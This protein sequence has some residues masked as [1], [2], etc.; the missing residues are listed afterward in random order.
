MKKYS[1]KGTITAFYYLSM[2][3]GDNT[4]NNLDSFTEICR[5]IDSEH[6]EEYRDDLINECESQKQ[7]MIDDDDYYDVIIEG[8]DKT[9]SQSLTEDDKSVSARMLIW[10]LL[11][12]SII[13]NDYSPLERRMIKHIVRISE[14][15]T[16]AFLEMEQL[17]FSY[18]A[19][20]SEQNTLSFSTRPYVE[21]API[22]E[23]L[24][25]REKAI[26][27]SAQQ[28]IADEYMMQSIKAVHY[29]PDIIDNAGKAIADT[30]GNV[31]KGVGDVAQGIGNA[32]GGF[33]GGAAKMFGF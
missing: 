17:L 22:M 29:E 6:Y 4:E 12:I 9:L 20:V 19:V 25:K 15:E 2:I 18:N 26:F 33:F 32:V 14:I 27:D 31:A 7:K 13:D 8:L 5:E 3:D 10:N 21:I 11:V 30:A 1:Y 24:K 23:E 16:S 28:L